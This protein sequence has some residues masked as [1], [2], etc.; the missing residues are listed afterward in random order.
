MNLSIDETKHLLVGDN[1]TYIIANK[2]QQTYTQRNGQLDTIVMHYT[3]GR[4]A[5]SS[6]RYLARDSVKASAHLVIGREGEIYQLVPFD[7]VSWHAGISAYGGRTDYNRYSIGIELDNAGVLTRMGNEFQAWFGRRYLSNEVIEAVHRNETTPRDW[8]AY[9]EKQLAVNEEVVSLLLQTYPEIKAILGHEEIAPGRKVDPG[10]AFPLDRLRNNLLSNDRESAER[11]PVDQL[12][13]SG[14][15]MPSKLNIRSGPGTHFEM[16]SKPLS[17]GQEVKIED[18]ENNWYRVKVEID[19]W[20]SK[21]FIK[22][23]P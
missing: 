23:D 2:N 21:G 11:A 15:V 14:V 9:T 4:N 3:A 19:G 10:P 16:V 6:A 13:E 7:K 22:P 20:V 17:D 18:E 1:V 5:E 8:H 12:P